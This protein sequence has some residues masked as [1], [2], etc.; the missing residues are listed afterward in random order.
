MAAACRFFFRP[1]S[2]KIRAAGP[3]QV[4][5]GR[6]ALPA[7]GAAT[8]LPG[9]ALVG[10]ELIYQSARSRFILIALQPH[11]GV[12]DR[13]LTQATGLVRILNSRRNQGL[14][15]HI[16]DQLGLQDIPGDVETFHESNLE[17]LRLKL[18]HASIGKLYRRILN[19]IHIYIRFYLCFNDASFSTRLGAKMHI[20][21]RQLQVFASVA[22]HLSYTRAA[23]ELHLTQPAVSMQIKQLEKSVGLNLFEQIGK[24]IYLTEAGNVVLEHAISITSKLHSIE[25]DLE[26]LKGID[27]GRLTV[28]IASTVNY[29][30][31]RLI[32]RFSQAYPSVQISLDVTNRHELLKRLETN[33]PDLVLMGRPPSSADLISTAFMDN[34]LVIIANPH[35]PL[36]NESDIPIERLAAETFVLREQGSGTRA[37]M[38]EVFK[39]HG[40]EPKIGTQLSGNESIKQAVEAGLGLALVSF[41]TV[42]LELKAKRLTTLD[43]QGFP[44][45]KKWHIGYRSGKHLS[46]TARAFWDFVLEEADA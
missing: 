37:A 30:A 40:I 23:E 39:E 34:P 11:L 9:L 28:C 1:A 16:D 24:K 2:V 33:E 14:F 10:F 18:K 5:S 17:K 4:K 32:S 3:T 36:A 38:E 8:V 41:H 19:T 20:T 44:I 43:V 21:I 7:P 46:A 6:I 13:E 29:F 25:N 45:V 22:K 42:D 35:H 12:G 27:G 26:Q 31:T 15:Q